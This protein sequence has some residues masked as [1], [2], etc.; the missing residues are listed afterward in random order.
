MFTKLAQAKLYT[1]FLDYDRIINEARY[2][3]GGKLVDS[4]NT[5]V[6]RKG[7]YDATTNFASLRKTWK[8]PIRI[9]WWNR[10]YGITRKQ[11]L[12]TL[13]QRLRVV[14]KDTNTF[15]YQSGIYNTITHVRFKQ[16]K[17]P[18]AQ[19]HDRRR[20]D[21]LLTTSKN[22]QSEGQCYYDLTGRKHDDFTVRRLIHTITTLQRFMITHT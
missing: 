3:N 8:L 7:Y 19:L 16:R 14:D 13:W 17:R 21:I 6:S 20:Q 18:H 5:L 10:Q 11:R 9:M 12:S 15:N 22:I 1:D 4:I 2:Y